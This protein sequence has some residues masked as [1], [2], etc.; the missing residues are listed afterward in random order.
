MAGLANDF[1]RL[2]RYNIHALPKKLRRQM[3]PAPGFI[4]PSLPSRTKLINVRVDSACLWSA[5]K[6]TSFAII[7][8]V[9]GA[10]MAVIGFY[11]PDLSSH[12]YSLSNMTYHERNLDLHYHLK[13]LTY[14]GP[15]FMGLGCVIIV[16]IC[17]MTFE[18]RDKAAKICP[19]DPPPKGRGA[20]ELCVSVIKSLVRKYSGI[21]IPKA[22]PQKYDMVESAQLLP[23]SPQY[24]D[25]KSYSH[26]LETP[27]EHSMYLRTSSE[28]CFPTRNMFV[29]DVSVPSVYIA[30]PPSPAPASTSPSHT[31]LQPVT[32]PLLEERFISSTS[33]QSSGLVPRR[34]WNETRSSIAMSGETSVQADVHPLPATRYASSVN[35]LVGSTPNS[36]LPDI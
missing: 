29:L 9:I 23:T 5:C 20:D 22:S 26:L 27:M 15:A 24:E 10:T 12:E 16:A 13:N 25:R 2:K 6:S 30:M 11:A 21:H 14:V 36:P 33:I 28:P 19:E 7:L 17:V 3:A 18:A 32:H 4:E 8:I 1:V 31:Q 35:W 34:D